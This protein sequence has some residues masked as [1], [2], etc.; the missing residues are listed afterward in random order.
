ME[1]R[2]PVLRIVHNIVMTQTTATDGQHLFYNGS[3]IK[4]L[5]DSQLDALI[6]HELLHILKGQI[7]VT[8]KDLIVWNYACDFKNNNE[9]LSMGMDIPPGMPTSK[10]LLGMSEEKIYQIIYPWT[11]FKCINGSINRS[12]VSE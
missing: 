6:M 3:Y 9:L 8:D 7:Y 4:S 1:E 10:A 12:Q 5:S 11:K 2:L